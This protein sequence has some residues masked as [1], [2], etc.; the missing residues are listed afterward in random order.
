VVPRVEQDAEAVQA[1]ALASDRVIGL[2]KDVCSL[3][4]HVYL[5]DGKLETSAERLPGA[6]WVG[7][8]AD[9][10]DPKCL[11]TLFKLEGHEFDTSPPSRYVQAWAALSST[12]RPEAHE[13][14]RIVD[15]TRRL[16]WA[17]DVL[18]VAQ[19]LVDRSNAAYQLETFV[20]CSR[21]LQSFKPFRVAD[22]ILTTDDPAAATFVR[23]ERGLVHPP[24]YNRFGTR[25]GRMTVVAGPRVLTA[26]VATRELMR[27]I[28]D[29]HV[30]VSWDY[31]SLEAR[32]ALAL[33][34]KPAKAS[35]DP[36]E[37][38]GK[39]IKLKSRDEAKNATFSAIYS[40]PTAND[41]L[42]VKV[43]LVRRVFKLGET[44]LALS[45]E[46]EANG[47]RV[48]NL[49]GRLID[50]TGSDTLYNNYVQSTGADV[51]LLGFLSLLDDVLQM[52]VVPHFVLHDAL[53]ASVPR[54]RLDD[55]DALGREG[56]SVP[57]LG[58]VFPLKT[59]IVGERTKV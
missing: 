3:S 17:R 43:A 47:G 21:V 29:D 37:V 26:R 40:D 20:P 16:T 28:D 4:K 36:Y 38:I 32:V 18:R 6:A 58:C 2:E 27:P 7:V 1:R 31:S 11:R 57:R 45:A 59:S 48:R 39:A 25:T 10:S 34:G 15:P 51:V 41:R 19:S 44:Y 14:W 5:S 12:S 22:D 46:R 35:Q 56:A 42:D 24:T 8:E 30:L 49:Y 13:A 53:F 54:S 55:F 52:G 33:A 9:D 50:V 23:D